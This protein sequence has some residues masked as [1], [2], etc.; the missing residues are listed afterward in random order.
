MNR[1]L[2]KAI[3]G[4]RVCPNYRRHI[5]SFHPM[6]STH[7]PQDFETKLLR[8]KH[9]SNSRPST[10]HWTLAYH[11]TAVHCDSKFVT[12]HNKQTLHAKKWLNKWTDCVSRY[13]TEFLP[14]TSFTKDAE[15]ER[16]TKNRVTIHNE[17][18][19]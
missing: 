16:S 6:D 2:E 7:H 13:Q 19:N 15:I 10:K 12:L 4:S 8:V 17:G 11:K 5:T 9:P 1:R 3:Q 14:R 18:M